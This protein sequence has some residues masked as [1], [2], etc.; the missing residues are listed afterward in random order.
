[1]TIKTNH[2][3]VDLINI[4]TRVYQYHVSLF[5]YGRGGALEGTDI[6]PEE[7]S[8]TITACVLALRKLHPEWPGDFAYDGRSKIY[9]VAEIPPFAPEDV[10]LQSPSGATSS[11]RFRIVKFQIGLQLADSMIFAAEDFATMDIRNNTALEVALTSFARWGVV[12][13]DPTWFLARDKGSTLFH[14][15]EGAVWVNSKP[16]VIKRGYYLGLQTCMAGLTFV[17]DMTANLFLA[18]GEMIDILLKST[19][20]SLPQLRRESKNIY[21][22]PRRSAKVLADIKVRP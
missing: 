10:C 7:D 6:S 18:G 13:S 15:D 17:C 11:P 16:L 8:R 4:P 21:G 9:T 1:M 2:F 19:G 22:D 14:K 20:L 12:D 3:E 5:K